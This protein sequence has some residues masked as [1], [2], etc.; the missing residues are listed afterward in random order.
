MVVCATDCVI[1]AEP[2]ETTPP[3]GP[4]AKAGDISRHANDDL[5]HKR[6]NAISVR[7]RYI[8]QLGKTVIK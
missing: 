1:V 6:I 5:T 2:A 4:A 3:L 8:T 7:A